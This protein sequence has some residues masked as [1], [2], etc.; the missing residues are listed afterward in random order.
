MATKPLSEL[1]PREKG[2][3]V[4]VGGSRGVYRRILDMGVVAGSEVEVERV[5]PLGDPI[6]I[7]IKGY[8]LALRKQEAANVQ[9]EVSG[10]GRS[11]TLLTMA[12][13]G[14]PLRVL[15]I[16]A[17]WGLNR[18]LLGIGLTPGA[19]VRVLSTG[20]PGPLEIELRGSRIALGRGAA[21]KIVVEEG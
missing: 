7:K 11:A 14:K 15:S 13:P 18:R 9:V 3:I 12:P 19:E 20:G 5:A 8:H 10:D 1:R 4:E 2:T 21:Q 17:G 16:R 6:A